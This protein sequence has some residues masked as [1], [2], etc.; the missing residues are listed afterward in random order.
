MLDSSSSTSDNEYELNNLMINLSKNKDI[1]KKKADQ[2]LDKYDHSKAT[3]IDKRLV[4]GVI[5]PH[6][7]S[8]EENSQYSGISDE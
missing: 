7:S 4:K 1:I 2:C 6:F 8:D 5:D 3:N